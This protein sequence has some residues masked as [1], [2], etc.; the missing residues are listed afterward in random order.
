MVTTLMLMMLT[1]LDQKVRVRTNMKLQTST[2]KA[3]VKERVKT[4]KKYQNMML[5]KYSHKE[6]RRSLNPLPKIGP[7]RV[8]WA[9]DRILSSTVTK[10][11]P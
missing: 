6:Y 10:D 11:Y 4:Q 5:T 1:T 3:T 8:R 2:K 9:R 7:P